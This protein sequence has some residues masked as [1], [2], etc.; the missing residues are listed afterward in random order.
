DEHTSTRAEFHWFLL[1]RASFLFV[2]SVVPAMAAFEAAQRYETGLISQRRLGDAASGLESRKKRI[3]TEQS[4]FRLC[5]LGDVCPQAAAF[6]KRRINEFAYD[7]H[8]PGT[9]SL[10]KARPSADTWLASI[11]SSAHAAYNGVAVELKAAA[12]GITGT[13]YS[14]NSYPILG[15]LLALVVLFIVGIIVWPLYVLDLYRPPGFVTSVRYGQGGNLLLVGPAGSGKTDILLRRT[16]GTLVFDVGTLTFVDTGNASPPRP[17]ANQRVGSDDVG[18]AS[19]VDV[20]NASTLPENGVLAIDHLDYRMDDAPFRD[21][22]LPVLENLVYTRQYTVW[23]ATSLQPVEL[24]RSDPPVENADRWMRLLGTFRTQ[25]VDVAGQI[26]GPGAVEEESHV[27]T[28]AWNALSVECSQANSTSGKDLREE[29]MCSPRLRLMAADLTRALPKNPPPSHEDILFEFGVAAESYYRALFG[30]CSM[31]QKLALYQLSDSGGVN[32][33][34]ATVLAQ[35]LRNGLLRR[36][37]NFR[38]MNET[39][40]RFV[41]REMPHDKAVAW[42]H[43]GVRLPWGS[44]STMMLT[45]AVL[46]IGLMLLTQQQLVGVWVGALPTLAPVLPGVAKL[47]SSVGAKK[48]TEQA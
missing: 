18:A 17:N 6:L 47:I 16:P 29:S 43:E 14:P 2:V 42:E 44:I 31:D 15:A 39:F 23:I 9:D 4:S 48:A 10:A 37:P 45:V 7:V 22:M 11:L 13:S 5:E 27:M 12:P 3:A 19:W 35:L 30:A 34:N 26:S 32:P 1:A 41:A 40:R 38:V 21:L 24:L 46:P 25:M 28:E 33:R 8:V 36:D 20:L